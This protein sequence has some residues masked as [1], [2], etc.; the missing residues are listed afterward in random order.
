MLI[1]GRMDESDKGKKP[2]IFSRP[3][4]TTDGR[5]T[6]SDPGMRDTAPAPDFD[7][8]PLPASTSR[9]PVA[10]PVLGR[11]ANYDILG[12][13][14]LGGMAEIL[15]S[16]H[17]DPT[18]GESYLVVKKI[19]QHFEQDKDFVQMFLDEARIGM[20]LNHPN[21]CQFYQYGE[22]DGAHFI[23][24]EWIHG[25]PL[26]RLIRRAKR[27]GGIP[28][29]IGL[30]IISEIAGA[31]DHAHRVRDA[32][33]EPLRLIHRDV[34]PHNIMIGYNGVPKLL[35]FGI[36]KAE[37]QAHRTQAGV[38]KGKFAYMAPEQCI[39]GDLDH[40]LDIFALGVCL[41]E[42][43]AG[44]SLYRR[45]SEAATMRAVIMDPVPS[46]RE[47]VESIPQRVDEIV[48]KMLAKDPKDR[49]ATAGLLKKDI[50][51]FFALS[52]SECSSDRSGHICPTN[53]FG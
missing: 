46:I 18:G 26:A 25:V 40:R 31:L 41:Y 15:L 30:R 4:R 47:R 17:S 23:T 19:L 13:L 27:D 1:V 36:A 22:S 16:R 24:M 39:G 11:F 32:H 45:K 28:V 3:T 44:H 50:D 52:W 51:E 53:V 34:S 38:V 43:L 9:P 20:L 12:R 7:E 5:T 8:R 37:L 10:L 2:I 14:A 29:D 35:D 33:G 49:Y 6:M 48:Q 21:I 42:T